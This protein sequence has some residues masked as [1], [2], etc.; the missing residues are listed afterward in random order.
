MLSKTGASIHSACP[1][2]ADVW[3]KRALQRIEEWYAATH[4]SGNGRPGEKIEFR[5]LMYQT[6]LFRLN[7]PSVLFPDPTPEMRKSSLNAIIAIASVYSRNVRLGKLFYIWHALFQLFESG[8][9]LLETIISAVRLAAAGK[10]CYLTGFD[11]AVLTR[12]VRT[13]PQLLRKIAQRWP[14]VSTHAKFLEDHSGV[15]LDCLNHWS[16]GNLPAITTMDLNAETT[17]RR[18]LVPLETPTPQA[19]MTDHHSS[20]TTPPPQYL[21]LSALG[22]DEQLPPGF[23]DALPSMHTS[24]D[25]PW[26][27]ELFWNKSPNGLA[28]SLNSDELSWDFPGVELDQ[29][30]AA[31]KDGQSI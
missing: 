1:L 13:I 7:C 8:I 5:E 9:C 18:I 10:P 26:N 3:R 23:S 12:T 22:E 30:F 29:I 25:S 20:E 11:A 31:F 16:R 2:P 21:T 6:N 19:P 28:P 4:T 15:T 27:L 24:V 17:L 14:R